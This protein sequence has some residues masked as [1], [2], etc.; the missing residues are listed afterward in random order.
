MFAPE[1][2]LVAKEREQWKSTE[3]PYIERQTVSKTCKSNADNIYIVTEYIP[4]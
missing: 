1:W 4:T 3:E 2:M